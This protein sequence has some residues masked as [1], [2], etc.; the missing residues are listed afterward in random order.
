MK[1]ERIKK[2]LRKSKK[3]K[4]Q[5][6]HIVY[7]FEK[8]PES[9]NDLG[10]LRYHFIVSDDRFRENKIEKILNNFQEKSIINYPFDEVRRLEGKHY[11]TNFRFLFVSYDTQYSPKFLDFK[12]VS[13]NVKRDTD[14]RERK[15]GSIEDYILRK[16]E[17]LT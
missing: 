4:F 2:H 11:G 14:L 6:R 5:E 15:V 3:F 10:I 9:S 1:L 17:I 7:N 16:Y 12:G 8:S 13:E